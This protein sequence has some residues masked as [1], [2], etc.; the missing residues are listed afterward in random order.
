MLPHGLFMKE[1][2][3]ITASTLTRYKI[4]HLTA[5]DTYRS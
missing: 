1:E 2:K 5:T 3:A 4:S